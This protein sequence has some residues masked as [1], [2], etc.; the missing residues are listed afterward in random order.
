MKRALEALLRLRGVQHDRARRDVAHANAAVARARGETEARA[1][2]E[3]EGA[4]A[5]S[6]AGREGRPGPWWPGAARGAVRL[7]VRSAE[8]RAQ[9]AARETARA[10]AEQARQRAEQALRVIE[11]VKERREREER[12]RQE[13]A[14]QRAI[15]ERASQRR[16]GGVLAL[17]L[18]CG[19]AALPTPLAAADAARETGLAPLLSEL[20]AKQSELARKER[21]LAD[22]ERHAGELEAA[23]E[24][25]LAEA[26]A[27]A[28]QLEQRMADFEAAQGDKSMAR[29]ARIYGAMPPRA[30]AS[31]LEQL[32]LELATRIVGKM[33]PDQSSELLP[34]LS[35]ERALAL[36]RRVARPLA[37]PV[38]A[39]R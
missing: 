5:L 13:R 3:A 17:L 38:G 29:V 2:H 36:S 25:R 27:L 21:E 35:P 39:S 26:T 37:A 24:A 18:A 32:D 22:R 10:A 28:T 14:A 31:L 20:R 34:L 8:A 7:S 16:R 1:A 9:L 30:A 15:D 12:A 19:L 23:A 4:A 6:A 11:R 33:K